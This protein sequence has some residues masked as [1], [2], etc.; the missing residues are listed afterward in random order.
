MRST[1]KTLTGLVMVAGLLAGCGGGG[2][3]S[4]TTA[5][6]VNQPAQPT[7]PA[8]APKKF[9]A[10]GTSFTIQSAVPA[11][12]VTEALPEYPGGRILANK[13]WISLISTL[14]PSGKIIGFSGTEGATMT[15]PADVEKVC[16]NSTNFGFNWS[17]NTSS[18]CVAPDA[19]G[20][21]AFVGTCFPD[22]FWI[23]MHRKG[24]LP[25]LWLD[26]DPTVS[27]RAWTVDP[28]GL[29]MT[30]RASD[31]AMV[32]GTIIP[33]DIK[34]TRGANGTADI[35]YRSHSNCMGGFSSETTGLGHLDTG[36][37]VPVRFLWNCATCGANG[38][39]GWGAAP[40]VNTKT[41]V[42]VPPSVVETMLDYDATTETLSF[43]FKG[44]PCK[45]EGTATA[46]QGV[47]DAQGN[48]TWNN[49]GT[50]MSGVGWAVIEDSTATSH[51][52]NVAPDQDPTITAAF[53]RT[54]ENQ[55]FSYNA[56][57]V[58]PN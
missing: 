10:N 19:S 22:G 40:W 16:L 34:V 21:F 44:Q 4:P 38:G 56:C 41:G 7:T 9:M 33:A 37:G 30:R 29:P 51:M 2:S 52:W 58:Q 20:V 23:S 39:H 28:T 3:S 17:G 27:P 50:M 43:T 11:P 57:V 55:K 54:P 24:G 47:K 49:G 26:N 53:D 46:Y 5:P 1:L 12:S 18:Q 35:T 25:I 36:P 48:T 42:T 8:P 14:T 13:K 31:N 32:L 6:A 15:A 45:G